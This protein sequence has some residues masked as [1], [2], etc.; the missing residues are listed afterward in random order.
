M[1][2]L[3]SKKPKALPVD[4]DFG[5]NS[6][7]II[8]IEDENSKFNV[9]GII[10][11]NGKTDEDEIA[12]LKKLFE[13]LNINPELVFIIADWI[14][15]DS[16]PRLS[17][18]EDAAKN[19]FIWSVDELR[20]IEGIDTIFDE[21]EPYITVFENTGS[22]VYLININT[23]ELPVIFSLDP[24]MTKILAQ[25]IIDE[26]NNFPFEKAE[27]V[28]NVAGMETI[29]P[30]LLQRRHAGALQP[31]HRRGGLDADD[32]LVQPLCARRCLNRGHGLA[33]TSGDPARLAKRLT[34]LQADAY[35]S[36]S[37]D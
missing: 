22:L 13:F 16:E 17:N 6:S 4:Y 20:L 25:N 7:L 26:R 30:R 2:S 23:A 8:E 36:I 27:Q 11:P 33:N 3:A 15:P 21:I 14:D 31:D 35:R 24:E 10:E 32:R 9:N 29:G 1:L 28:Q 34:P 5:P 19:D 37:Y 18:S 12:S